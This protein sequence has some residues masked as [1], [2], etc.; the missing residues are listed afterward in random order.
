MHEYINIKIYNS[1][2]GL[3][4]ACPCSWALEPWSKGWGRRRERGKGGPPPRVPRSLG[5][6]TPAAR[7]GCHRFFHSY[8]FLCLYNYSVIYL[9][10]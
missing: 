6:G 4:E 7:K 5:R 1:E 9:Y 3:V 8:K 2:E 10:R